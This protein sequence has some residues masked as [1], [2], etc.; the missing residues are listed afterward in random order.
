[1]KVRSHAIPEGKVVATFGSK[2]VC[3]LGVQ[4]AHEGSSY[5]EYAR[6]V[7]I[8]LTGLDMMLSVELDT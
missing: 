2:V 5:V 6:G 3:N 1:M 7:G 8:E 4:V